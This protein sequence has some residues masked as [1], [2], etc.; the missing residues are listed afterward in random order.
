MNYL[1]SLLPPPAL[2][3]AFLAASLLLALTPGP[4]VLY[5]LTRSLSQGARAG[6]AS[7]AGVALGNFANALL[8]AFGL[9]AI[10]AVAPLAFSAMKFTGALYLL[11][12]GAS[13]LLKKSEGEVIVSTSAPLGATFRDGVFVALLNPKTTIFFA[14]F[15]PQFLSADAGVGQTIFLGALFVLIAASTD[16]LYALL[17]GK[18]A[19]LLKKR[20]SAAAY[21]RAL[22]GAIYI[23]LGIFTA[24]SGGKSSAPAKG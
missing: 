16:S 1:N 9:A 6:L 5:I 12:L 3:L 7:V 14:A 11:Y 15:L 4:G 19:G 21:G 2:F 8:A 10:F 20:D 18:L 17:A 22:T 24:F 23:G 13:T